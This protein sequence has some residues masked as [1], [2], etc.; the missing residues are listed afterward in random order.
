MKEIKKNQKKHLPEQ[1]VQS[2]DE[3][4]YPGLEG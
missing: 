3:S 1:H 4:L 2:L